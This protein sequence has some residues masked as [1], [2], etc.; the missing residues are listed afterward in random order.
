MGRKA[1]N[2]HNNIL[3]QARLDADLSRAAVYDKTQISSNVLQ[4]IEKDASKATP[5]D[6]VSLADVYGKKE[7][8][9]NY[10]SNIC[11]IGQKYVPHI[12]NVS[13][14]P[15]ITLGLISSLKIV[16]KFLDRFIE[17]S[18]DGEID[19]DE[20]E[21]FELFKSHLDELSLAIESLKLWENQ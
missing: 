8:C 7:L 18:A 11:E 19:E 6:V 14:L 21:D 20:Q 16:E 4:K 12:T 1:N 3:L 5:Q 9:N 2:D 10:C 17:M 15:K 13:D